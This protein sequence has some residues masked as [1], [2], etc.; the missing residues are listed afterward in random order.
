MEVFT[1]V[2]VAVTVFVLVFS[3]LLMYSGAFFTVNW[4]KGKPYEGTKYLA[5]WYRRGKYSE[6]SELFMRASKLFGKHNCPLFGVY[7]DKDSNDSQSRFAVGIFLPEKPSKELEKL[8]EENEMNR[9][10]LPE[11]ETGLVAEFP[12]TTRFSILLSIFKV[13][14]ALDRYLKTHGMER[15][16]PGACF[17]VCDP[18]KPKELRYFVVSG[19][20]FVIPEFSR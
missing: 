4:R 10:D 3:L 7:Y 12:F 13:Y 15:K 1:V 17:E 2:L 16:D 9:H 8:L 19:D 6:S 18:S 20:D 5:Y 14:P 11:V